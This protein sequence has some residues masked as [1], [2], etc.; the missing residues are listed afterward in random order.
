MTIGFLSKS[1]VESG[2]EVRTLYAAEGV[3][4]EEREPSV[5]FVLRVNMQVI[6][7]E[8]YHHEEHEGHKVKSD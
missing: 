3:C 6:A 4:S 7:I 1:V 2:Q 5:T 8:K